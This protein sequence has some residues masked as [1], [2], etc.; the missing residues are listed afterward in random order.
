MCGQGNMGNACAFNKI[1]FEPKTS[2]KIKSIKN[3]FRATKKIQFDS[4][5]MYSVQIFEYC[6]VSDIA[7]GANFKY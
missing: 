6:V 2:L 4:V 7:I 3:A 1:C 5:G